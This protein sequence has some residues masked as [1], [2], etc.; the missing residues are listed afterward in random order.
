MKDYHIEIANLNRD[1]HHSIKRNDFKEVNRIKSEIADIERLIIKPTNTMEKEPF[2]DSEL[3]FK[4]ALITA[5]FTLLF[6]IAS[7]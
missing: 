3:L 5:V 1:L 2:F 4:I 6:L 7:L